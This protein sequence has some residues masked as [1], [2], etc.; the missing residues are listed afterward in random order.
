MVN[1]YEQKSIINE[2]K[3]GD[4]HTAHITMMEICRLSKKE[5]EDLGKEIEIQKRMK[6]PS[7]LKFIG[8]IP[9]DFKKQKKSLSLSL[10][11]LQTDHY[12]KFLNFNEMDHYQD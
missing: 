7:L 12:Q 4:F 6:H 10:N 9:I 11:Y 8:F 2:K 3:T 5:K 1:Q